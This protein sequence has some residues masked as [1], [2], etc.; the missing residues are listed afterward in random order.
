MV[1]KAKP[2]EPDQWAIVSLPRKYLPTE[3][4]LIT[5]GKLGQAEVED[6]GA[7][8]FGNKNIYRV[9]IAMDDAMGVSGVK[10]VGRFRLPGTIRFLCPAGG[11]RCGASGVGHRETPWR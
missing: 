7:A 4:R 11:P 10:S 2:D 8:A 1:P 3:H 9:D 5:L 6:L